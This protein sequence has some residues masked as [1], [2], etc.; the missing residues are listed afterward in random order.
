MTVFD[1]LKVGDKFVTLNDSDTIY[2]KIV[3]YRIPDPNSMHGRLIPVNA[4][5]VEGFLVGILDDFAGEIIDEA[6]NIPQSSNP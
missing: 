2:M 3:E 5:G 1:N 4:V 6:L